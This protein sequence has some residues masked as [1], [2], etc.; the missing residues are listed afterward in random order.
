MVF[1]VSRVQADNLASVC[2]MPAQTTVRNALNGQ[3]D[4]AVVSGSGTVQAFRVQDQLGR[5]ACMHKKHATV[6]GIQQTLK[7]VGNDLEC[8][9]SVVAQDALHD[10]VAGVQ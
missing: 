9:P 8:P 10:L 7:A 3:P 2:N 4:L 5:V 6:F 1:Q